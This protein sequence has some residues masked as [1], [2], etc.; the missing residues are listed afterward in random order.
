MS[1]NVIFVNS[2]NQDFFK[3]VKASFE[4]YCSKYNIDLIIN[5]SE[6]VKHGVRMHV[7]GMFE[8]FQ[9]YDLLDVYDRVC[10]IDSDIYIKNNSPN[11]FDEVPVN[12][13]G[14]YCESKDLNRD[15]FIKHM[16]YNFKLNDDIR[17]YYNSGVMVA[18]QMHKSM[19]NV[20]FLKKFFNR[21]GI[22]T[23]GW[24]DQD[25]INYHIYHR[26]VR[27]YDIG[28]KYNYLHSELKDS[29]LQ[30]AY[31]VHFAGIPNRRQYISDFLSN[32]NYN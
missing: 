6:K 9:I 16:K 28:Y 24:P 11:I 21:G 3:L 32:Y 5:T 23:G 17:L 29:R 15:D 2:I 19:F 14:I 18:S 10:Y 8:R 31:F 27:V 13:L 30:S 1:K 22:I 26:E 4:N 12:K 25:Y 7:K 20:T